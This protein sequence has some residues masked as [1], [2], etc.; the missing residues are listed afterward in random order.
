MQRGAVCRYPADIWSTSTEHVACHLRK[1]HH[2]Y[3]QMLPTGRQMGV[4]SWKLRCC[5]EFGARNSLPRSM[6][7]LLSLMDGRGEGACT[8]TERAAE[9]TGQPQALRLAC[10]K[11]TGPDALLYST[12]STM[13]SKRPSPRAMCSRSTVRSLTYYSLAATALFPFPRPSFCLC[14][15]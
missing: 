6:L 12:C 5:T 8:S 9:F 2:L 13:Y 7:A 4:K 10:S 14:R 15:W 11:A 1:N 3:R